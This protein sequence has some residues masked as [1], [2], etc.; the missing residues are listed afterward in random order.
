M[1]N[2]IFPQNGIICSDHFDQ[3]DL[4]E[5]LYRTKLTDGAIPVRFPSQEGFSD[6][7]CLM[8]SEDDIVMHDYELQPFKSSN[9]GK[10]FYIVNVQHNSVA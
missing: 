3:K 10:P 4:V 6:I 2:Q 1:N 9:K 8:D 7:E 5:S